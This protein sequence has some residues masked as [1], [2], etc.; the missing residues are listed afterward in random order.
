M[1]L[2]SSLHKDQK[3]STLLSDGCQRLCFLVEF[4][5]GFDIFIY[6]YIYIHLYIYIYNKYI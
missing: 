1:P 2:I 3:T 5:L 6:K 4:V